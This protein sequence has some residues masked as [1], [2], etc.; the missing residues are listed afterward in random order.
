MTENRFVHEVSTTTFEQAVLQRSAEVPVVVDFWAP[1]CGPCRQLGPVLERLAAAAD[2]AW[3]LAKVDTDQNPQIAQRYRIQG[4]PAVK[5][6]RDGQVVAEF[7]GAKPESAVRAFLQQLTPSE[8]E[9]AVAEG[10]RLLAQGDEAGATIK[11][12]EALQADPRQ[13]KALLILGDLALRQGHIQDAQHY[14]EQVDPLSPE[15]KRAAVLLKQIRFQIDAASLSAMD[16][17]GQKLAEQGDDPEAL[18]VLGAHAAAAGNYADALQHYIQLV[19]S[20]R[21]F[22]EDGG[23]KSML[24]IFDILGAEDP[25]TIEYRSRLSAALH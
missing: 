10:T 3:E 8:A 22:R 11:C 14:L 9:L 12:Q 6:F 19:E 23:R 15:G 20:H 25:L 17:A 2:G 4:I 5:A 18:W 1:W 16:L 24:A 7:V 21:H 13:Q